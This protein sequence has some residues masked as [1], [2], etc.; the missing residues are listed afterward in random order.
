MVGNTLREFNGNCLTFT[1]AIHFN[2]CFL[3]V[4]LRS[5]KRTHKRPQR[6]NELGLMPL[7]VSDFLP[8]TDIYCYCF[9]EMLRVFPSLTLRWTG[10][11]CRPG[12]LPRWIHVCTTHKGG[13]LH[14]HSH[15]H[16]HTHILHWFP[17][18]VV[19]KYQQMSGPEIKTRGDKTWDF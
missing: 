4:W 16:T 6:E 11:G 9:G 14:M 17:A 2:P 7:V 5:F 8:R 13:H 19:C 3:A 1:L 10:L 18:A 12:C 15:T